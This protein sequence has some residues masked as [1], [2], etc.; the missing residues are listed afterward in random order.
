METEPSHY[1]AGAY[2]FAMP[3]WAAD[4]CI[5]FKGEKPVVTVMGDYVCGSPEFVKAA[6]AYLKPTQKEVKPKNIDDTV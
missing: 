6:K 5:V 2:G 4:S 1:I 3:I